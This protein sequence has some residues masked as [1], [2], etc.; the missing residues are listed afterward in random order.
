MLSESY[1][2]PFALRTTHPRHI[3]RSREL[4]S[5]SLNT[6]YFEVIEKPSVAATST[7]FRGLAVGTG[8]QRPPIGSEK[9]DTDSHEGQ[10][11]TI[12]ALTEI[13]A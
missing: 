6:S 5:L 13:I 8:Y 2:D 7:R 9:R 3:S 12:D 1:R 11:C 10:Q 4:L